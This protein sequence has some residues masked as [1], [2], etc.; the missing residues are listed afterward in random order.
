[1]ENNIIDCEIIINGVKLNKDEYKSF[2]DKFKKELIEI[3]PKL[4]AA[5]LIDRFFLYPHTQKE[6]E[7]AKT[8]ALITVHEILHC[9]SWHNYPLDK[10]YRFWKD[11]E[12]NIKF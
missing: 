11:V 5:E 12:D 4:K 8:N 1:M 6:F 9:I 10:Q 7:I 3:T 2:M